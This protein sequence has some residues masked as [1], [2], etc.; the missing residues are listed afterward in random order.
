MS[1]ISRISGLSQDADGLVSLMGWVR[2]FTFNV[3]KSARR[4]LCV[5]IHNLN[6]P[7]N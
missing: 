6:D 3:H 7:G 1:M 2:G 4:K 5:T